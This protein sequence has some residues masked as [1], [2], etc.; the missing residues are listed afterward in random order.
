[1]ASQGKIRVYKRVGKKKTTY[2][3]LLEAGK[4]INGKRKRV[5]KSGF[6][7]AKEARAAALPVLNEL[8]LGKNIVAS[9]ITFKEYSYKWLS[10]REVELKPATF[11]RLKYSINAINKYL[12]A[13]KLKE[14]N[15]Y[16]YQ[17]FINKYAMQHSYS[18]VIKKNSIAKQII[19]QAVKFS[20]ILSDPTEGVTI[21]KKQEK[22]ANVDTLYLTKDELNKL[23]DYTKNNVTTNGGYFYY[24]LMVLIYTGLRVGEASALIWENINFKDKYI[25]VD[26]T[27]FIKNQNNYLRQDTPKT[28]SS[29]RKVIIDDVLINLLKEW[30]TKQLKLRLKRATMNKHDKLAYVFTRYS[31]T[32]DRELPVMYS[33][34]YRKFN[35]LNKTQII[36]K[37][38]HPHILRHT[39]ASLLAEAG[40]PLEAIQERLGHSDDKTTKQIYLHITEKQKE[41]A[42]SMFSSYMQSNQ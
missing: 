35:S 19:Q 37:N 17:Q 24:F 18:T 3:Y 26:S 15:L 21:P 4:D 29:I 2:T 9:N 41:N 33:N 32:K 5:T 10:E 27:M 12:G 7:T 8:L 39:H 34:I 14:I 16:T 11:L 20:I 6:K 28:N 40:V 36:N 31:F 23:I 13:F 30:K 42:A 22:P 38:L 1:M 25:Y